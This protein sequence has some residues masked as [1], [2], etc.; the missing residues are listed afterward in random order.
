M[1]YMGG[2]HS[3]RLCCVFLKYITSLTIYREIILIELPAVRPGLSFA[4]VSI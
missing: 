2:Q 3:V 4:F 1:W